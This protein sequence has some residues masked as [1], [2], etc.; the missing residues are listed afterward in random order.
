MRTSQGLRIR[1]WK[2]RFP[3]GC[4]PCFFFFNGR[5]CATW[6]FPGQGL[7]LSCTCSHTQS[8]NP[9]HQAGDQ[10]LVSTGTRDAAVGFLTHCATAGTPTPAFCVV[11]FLVFIYFMETIPGIKENDRWDPS[12]SHLFLPFFLVLKGKRGK[13]HGD[14]RRCF[15]SCD[16]S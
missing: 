15:V 7:N 9:L 4:N 2:C 14:E 12:L 11:A 6:E 5:T 1:I 8:F 16:W 10:T 13:R 3:P